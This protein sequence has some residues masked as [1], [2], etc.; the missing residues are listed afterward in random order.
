MNVKINAFVSNENLTEQ[1]AIFQALNMV[2]VKDKQNELSDKD[3]VTKL[4]FIAPKLGKI[5]VVVNNADRDALGVPSNILANTNIAD[6]P[7]ERL[8]AQIID[9]SELIIK[10]GTH[11]SGESI[12]NVGQSMA[13]KSALRIMPFKI[14]V[15]KVINYNTDVQDFLILPSVFGANIFTNLSGI[16]NN[17]DSSVGTFIIENGGKTPEQVEAE[18]LATIEAERLEAQRLEAERLA[19]IEAV[20]LAKLASVGTIVNGKLVVNEAMLKTMIVNKEDVTNIDT[21]LVTNMNSLFHTIDFNQDISGW[22]V[23]NVTDMAGMFY[24]TKFNRDISGWDVSNVKFMSSMFCMTTLFNQDIS[25]WDVSSVTDMR[26]MFSSSLAFNKNLSN[27]CVAKIPS[28]PE[29]FSLNSKLSP[30]NLPKWGTC[31]RGEILV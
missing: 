29:K 8:P 14:P 2:V 30:S 13:E 10:F 18:R 15:V 21:S 9:Y 22:D 24:A 17:G 5:L 26:N 3:V 23:S 27:W 28:L 25:G 6:Y 16:V 20:R 7:L 11:M 1:E 12:L 19:L 31:P 4:Y